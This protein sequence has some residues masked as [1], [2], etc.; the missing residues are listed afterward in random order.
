MELALKLDIDLYL[1][2]GNRT[3]RSCIARSKYSRYVYPSLRSY[4]ETVYNQLFGCS[5]GPPT[6]L[7]PSSLQTQAALPP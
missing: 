2:L 5:L 3:M 6:T 4:R 1:V 7:G